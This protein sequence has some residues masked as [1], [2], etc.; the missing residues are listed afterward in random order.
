MAMISLFR[1][2]PMNSIPEFIERKNSA[3]KITYFDPRMEKYLDQSYGVIVYQDDVLLTAVNIAGYNWEEADNFR[4]AMG[5]KI[6]AEMTKQKE[7]FINGCIKNGMAQQKAEE[8]FKLIEPFAA[9]GFNKA[10]AASYAIIAYQTAYMKANYPVEF[11]TAVM[12]AESDNP[13]K[14]SAAVNECAKMN[15]LVLPPDIN[16]SRTGFSIEDAK[17]YIHPKSKK[18]YSQGV[19]FGLSAIKNV[20]KA[21][22]EAIISQ[23]KQSGPFKNLNDFVKRVNLRA[24]NR[25]TMESLIKAGA[26]DNFGKRNAMLKVL[27]D[28]K[29]QGI[30]L[31]KSIA[32]G[33]S[34]LFDETELEG[35]NAGTTSIDTML[36][37]VEEAPKEEILSWERELLGFYLSEH[38]LTKVSTK[39]DKITTTKIGEID[40]LFSEEKQLKLGG[41]ISQIRKTFTKVKKEEMCFL[42]LQDTTGTIDILVFPRVFHQARDIL[43]LDQIVVVSGKLRSNEETPIVIAEKISKLEQEAIEPQNTSQEFKIIIPKNA[44]RILLSRIYEL[45]KSNPGKLSTYLILPGLDSESRK[46]PV[47]FTIE[48][49][50]DLEEALKN[51]GCRLTN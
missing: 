16:A 48:K 14:I 19:R 20:G 21:A 30:S 11:M 23:R 46:I 26:L 37:T 31:S 36:N 18:Y 44:N 4:K 15:I 29:T 40:I 27:D 41:I 34:A 49:N 9:Y 10:H 2:G 51:L 5:K 43:M 25:K 45:L 24:V 47:P 42:K 12:T 38:P 6:P 28:L 7:K 22:I 17:K 32:T 13:D 3:R 33:Q 8:L 39:L 1:P 35:K 50:Y